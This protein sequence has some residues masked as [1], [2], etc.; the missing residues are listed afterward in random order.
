MLKLKDLASGDLKK[1]SD[2]TKGLETESTKHFKKVSDS[3]GLVKKAVVGLVAV[4]AVR[5]IVQW[6][7]QLAGSFMSMAIQ[8]ERFEF[9]LRAVMD[10]NAKA[11]REALKEIRA[12]AYA[13]PF[14][15]AKVTEAYVMMSAVG[16]DVTKDMMT[17]IGDAAFAMGKEIEGV[18]TAM[19]SME[20]EVLRRLGVMVD[21]TG[22]QA[23]VTSGDLTMTVANNILAIRAAVL[24]MFGRF[25]GAMKEAETTWSGITAIMVSQWDEFKLAV[26]EGPVFEVLKKSL[27]TFLE[28][29][30]K[31]KREGKLD[32]WARKIA[33]EVLNLAKGVLWL[34]KVLGYLPEVLLTISRAAQILYGGFVQLIEVA[35][36]LSKA[37]F[38]ANPVTALGYLTEKIA[39]T[40]GPFMTLYNDLNEIDDAMDDYQDQLMEDI[41]LNVEAQ[42]KWSGYREEL[43]KILGPIG[44]MIALGQKEAFVTKEMTALEKED[45]DQKKKKSAIQIA[46]NAATLESSKLLEGY[47]TN[48]QKAV[49]AQTKLVDS[50]DTMRATLG[51]A[52]AKTTMPLDWIEDLK[53]ALDPEKAKEIINNFTQNLAGLD[54]EGLKIN[55]ADM[56]KAGVIDDS[57]KQDLIKQIT[58]INN[59]SFEASVELAKKLKVINEAQ[60]KDL[61][62]FYKDNSAA[63]ILAAENVTNVTNAEGLKQVKI[64]CESYKKQLNCLEEMQ[65]EIDDI[66]KTSAEL[67][68]DK[69]NERYKEYEKMY[70]DQYKD[71]EE[72]SEKLLELS[73]KKQGELLKVYEVA[74]KDRLD[75]YNKQITDYNA[76][77]DKMA[78]TF[79]SIFIESA[80]GEWTGFADYFDEV[81][82]RIKK[83]MLDLVTT[84][85]SD[86]AFGLLKMKLASS[87]MGAAGGGTGLL[88]GMMGG[89]Q[90]PG[91]GAGSGIGGFVQNQ[92]MSM[93]GKYLT[94]QGGLYYPGL[95][96]KIPGIGGMLTTTSAGAGV[97]GPT[98]ASGAFYT[99]P[100]W[101]SGVSAGAMGAGIGGAIGGY[102]GGAIGKTRGYGAQIGSASGIGGVS[103]A[104]AGA[105]IAAMMGAGIG[106]GAALGGIGGLVIAAVM[107][108]MQGDQVKAMREAKGKMFLTELDAWMDA[109]YESLGGLMKAQPSILRSPKYLQYAQ[110]YAGA[111]GGAESFG[112]QK[113]YTSTYEITDKIGG[114]SAAAAGSVNLLSN[115]IEMFN[116]KMQYE[117]VESAEAQEEFNQKIR[118]TWKGDLLDSFAR[119]ITSLKNVRK[120]LQNL[121]MEDAEVA[122]ELYKTALA[123]LFNETIPMG[124]I[125]LERLYKDIKELKDDMSDATSEAKGMEV[126]MTAMAN[127]FELTGEQLNILRNNAENF[128][129]IEWLDVYD[130]LGIEKIEIAATSMDTLDGAITV[131]RTSLDLATKSTEQFRSFADTLPESMNDIKR[132]LIEAS[133][134]MDYFNRTMKEITDV[135]EDL[136]NIQELFDEFK[137]VFKDVKEAMDAED[138]EAYAKAF[139][140]IDIGAL[141]DSITSLNLIITDVVE[142]VTMVGGAFQ[143]LGLAQ[144]AKGFENVALALT[145]VSAAIQ[146][147]NYL[148]IL[149][150]IVKDLESAWWKFMDAVAASQD[151]SDEWEK[152]KQS[153]YDNIVEPT[154]RVLELIPIIGKVIAAMFRESAKGKLFP[155]TEDTWLDVKELMGNIQKL[156]EETFHKMT[157]DYIEMF[158]NL[159]K[160]DLVI[161]VEKVRD[162]AQDYFN[163]IIENYEQLVKD[164]GEKNVLEIMADAVAVYIDTINE[165]FDNIVETFTDFRDSLTSDI[166][167][168]KLEGAKAN[169]SIAE[170]TDEIADAVKRLGD[171]YD[172]MI[173]EVERKM[174]EVWTD[175]GKMK[176]FTEEMDPAEYLSNAGELRQLILDRYAL[177]KQKI[178]D[179]VQTQ[180]QAMEEIE[181]AW[182]GVADSIAD[183]ILNITT[184]TMNPED[185]LARLGIQ[186]EEVGRLRGLYQGA[187][188]TEKAGY[189]MDLANALQEYLSMAGEAWQ[190]PTQQYGDIYAAVLAELEAMQ[191]TS[192]NEY[193]AAE[194]AIIDLLGEDRDINKA[195]E[196]QLADLR[197]QT[198]QNLEW[199]DGEVEKATLTL[200]GMRDDYLNDIKLHTGEMKD[201]LID[202]TFM[203]GIGTE[204]ETVAQA[205]RIKM[206]EMVAAVANLNIPDPNPE[207]QTQTTLLQDIEWNT[208]S[209]WDKLFPSAQHGMERVPADMPIF[210]HKDE[211]IVPANEARKPRV[212]FSVGDI[213]VTAG[214]GAD[215]NQIADDIAKGLE[216]RIKYG[217]LGNAIAERVKNA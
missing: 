136:S 21:R 164:L 106:M 139:N 129:K 213:Y 102:A 166:H 33:V 114:S 177:E 115:S 83:S 74:N 36:K 122:A 212:A 214:N 81:G 41:K 5:Q 201:Y 215:G 52:F 194:S 181:N 180:V 196:S 175:M 198:I 72:L 131:M 171:V 107:A 123:T 161:E 121:G 154:A 10:G 169:L 101:A 149:I 7:S 152:Y 140:A 150:K 191:A 80:T 30:E 68:I 179:T 44:E 168:L 95:V 20:T 183:M 188:G 90:V 92:A 3:I 94:G 138:V 58:V 209:A 26:M 173:S 108:I 204:L 189:S 141:A 170:S 28:Q 126:I 88:G 48:L 31:L 100:Q 208:R 91:G 23:I 146:M 172:E 144:V 167:G 17:K 142:A 67:E 163:Y 97:E 174:A 70:K 35:V 130:A 192:L 38:F 12:F 132:V 109:D 9:Q 53:K 195:I 4:F 89:G 39:G 158:E 156:S 62:K 200:E 54:V 25:E 125:Q 73:G 56:V 151:K 119:G 40:H 6:F 8:M 1:F 157:L 104:G 59:E 160:S 69:I 16:I 66:G 43:V 57:V 203:A 199:L 71:A 47:K 60:Y 86:W 190:R 63:Q 77:I 176:G 14:E 216:K 124:A 84:M 185:A 117:S 197:A 37:L 143:N 116:N 45:I 165:M 159:G 147:F 24:E 193:T 75:D 42:K 78:D 148:L 85:I 210:V 98:M 46:L 145:Y 135:I 153:L 162:A 133:L 111:P 2:K 128:Q 120:E 29:T 93:G 15:I 99:Q 186:K 134:A 61:M 113:Q 187:T 34:I 49:D 127:G 96:S 112:L 202:G 32:E 217:D 51:A 13:T 211:E 22:K 65:K 206:G 55:L 178:I 110:E 76:H 18:A 207:L 184:T 82:K 155:D 103:G 64:K 182:K 79:K 50:A 137:D 19:V 11:A 87:A 118:E 205:D 105:G 27:A